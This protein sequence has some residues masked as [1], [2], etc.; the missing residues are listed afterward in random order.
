MYIS[1]LTVED[2]G[3]LARLDLKFAPGL[4]VI[5]GARGTGKT[6]I[7]ELIRF[8]LDA[9]GFTEDAVIRGRQ[10]AMAVLGGGAV[11][12]EMTDPTSGLKTLITRTF[13]GQLVG[14][15]SS[16]VRATVLAQNEIEAVGAQAAGRLHLIDRFRETSL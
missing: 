16:A 5:I 13:S 4:N 9:G 12:V 6:S 11:T 15:S 2:E 8:C 10:Q 3:F 7:I 1:R 14:S